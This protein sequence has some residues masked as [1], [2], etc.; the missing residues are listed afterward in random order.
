MFI[1]S[2]SEMKLTTAAATSMLNSADR[3]IL[4]KPWHA[5]CKSCFGSLRLARTCF[6]TATK[7]RI[8]LAESEWR[9]ATGFGQSQRTSGQATRRRHCVTLL[10]TWRRACLISQSLPTF[11]SPARGHLRSNPFAEKAFGYQIGVVESDFLRP[12]RWASQT[13]LTGKSCGRKHMYA[14][15]SL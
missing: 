4:H 15:Y 12:Q 5:P 13:R 7:L 3:S 2:L 10:I 1:G 8:R 11:S 9:L 6:I 14:A